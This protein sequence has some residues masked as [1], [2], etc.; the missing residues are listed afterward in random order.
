MFAVYF[1]SSV[2]GDVLGSTSYL[3]SGSFDFYGGSTKCS[4]SV[5]G[6]SCSVVLMSASFGGRRVAFFG[7]LLFSILSSKDSSFG[8]ASSGSAVSG[9]SVG[10]G[11]YRFDGT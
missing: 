8:S 2:L 4:A 7:Y 10:G 1:S 3:S 6:F 5:F 11:G 9:P